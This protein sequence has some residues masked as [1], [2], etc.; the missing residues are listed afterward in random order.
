MPNTV[1]IVGN[2]AVISSLAPY[3]TVTQFLQRHDR[4]TVAQ[5]LSDTDT[6]NPPLDP[7]TFTQVGSPANLLLLELLGEASGMFESAVMV[8]GKYNLVDLQLAVSRSVQITDNA[9][10]TNPIITETTVYQPGNTARFIAGIVSDLTMYLCWDRRPN[11]DTPIP[12]KTQ[13]AFEWLEKLRDGE[14]IF[15]LQEQ[16]DAGR[17]DSFVESPPDVV[18]RNGTV[19]QAQNVFGVRANRMLPMQNGGGSNNPNTF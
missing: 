17:I 4:R 14:R 7:N 16:A 19:V 3:A 1:N 11:R 13:L 18:H 5:W 8:G 9:S 15:A 10:P 12:P 2:A 6:T